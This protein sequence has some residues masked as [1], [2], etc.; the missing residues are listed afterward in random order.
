MV[1]KGR[2][3]RV[4][5]GY[6]EFIIIWCFLVNLVLV[7]NEIGGRKLCMF[8]IERLEFCTINWLI[9]IIYKN[10]CLLIINVIFF[11]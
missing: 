4:S 3:Y 2:L 9:L 7:C 1:Y 8:N 10:I 11:F 5:F 6:S